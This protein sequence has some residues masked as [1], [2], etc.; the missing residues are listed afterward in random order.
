MRVLQMS[1]QALQSPRERLNRAREHLA[2][3]ADLIGG[4][5]VSVIG[6]ENDKHMRSAIAKISEDIRLRLLLTYGR[7]K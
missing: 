7:G 3:A 2:I 5:S 6:K 1:S 4:I